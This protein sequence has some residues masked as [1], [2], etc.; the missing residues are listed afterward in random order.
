MQGT[1]NERYDGLQIKIE[2]KKLKSGK[3]QIKFF[4]TGLLK[5]DFYGYTLVEGDRT[6]MEV[7]RAIKIRLSDVG[8]INNY[9]QKNLYSMKRNRSRVED[10]VL[11][12]I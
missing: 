3:C 7:I 10:F 8:N 4:T 5:E 6:L 2:S 11:F 9:Y 12:K 1:Y